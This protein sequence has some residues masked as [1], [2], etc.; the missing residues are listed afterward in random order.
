MATKVD[1]V[2]AGNK[3]IVCQN[4]DNIATLGILKRNPLNY[5][6]PLILMQF[7]LISLTSQMIEFC[8]RPL[9]QSS[10]VAQILGG[11]IYGPSALGHDALIGM[12]LFPAR[13]VLTLRTV[14][15]FGIMFFFFAVGV[16]S[17]SRMMVR[18][19][20]RAAVI[21]ISAMLST[22]VLT[23]SF[24]FLLI[25]YVHMDDSLSSAL[26][27]IAASQ[28]LTAFPNIACLLAELQLSSSDL[29]RIA[30]AAAMVCDIFGMGLVAV[31]LGIVQSGSDPV[32]SAL[33]VIS[34]CLFVIVMVYVIG[35]IIRIVIRSIPAGKP[36]AD[37]YVFF[38]FAGTLVTAFVTEVIGQHFILGPLVF[39]LLTPDGQP[40]GS[41]MVSKLDYPIGKFLYPTFLTTSGLKTNIF[42]IDRWSLLIVVLLI[43]FSCISKIAA[44]A[45]SSRFFDIRFKDSVVIGLMLNARGICELILYNLFRDNGV[46]TDKEFALCVISVVGVTAVITPLIRLLYDPSKQYLPSKRRTIQHMK[47]DAELRIVVCIKN[48]ENV[49]S[50]VDLLEASD[51]TEESPI[52][53]LALLLV[54][55]V[56]RTTPMLAA[57][58]S[59]QAL[60]STNSQSGHILG[61]LRQYQ[62]CHETCVTV[63]SFSVFSHLNST[64]DDICRVARDQKANIV[65][66]PFH[67]RWE[68]D[69]SIG[70]Q[71]RTVQNMNIKI[72]E[73]APCSVGIL[74]D[75][76]ILT[77]S[78]SILSNQ[79]IFQVAVI[80]IGGPDD[81]ESLFY[82]ARMGRRNNVSLTIL[83]FLLFGCDTARERKQDNNLIDEVRQANM[84]NQNNF[85][86]QERV[87]KDGVGLAASL[88]SLEDSFNLLLVGRHHH[89]SQ[90]LMG[91]GLGQRL[92]GEKLGHRLMRPMMISHEL[93]HEPTLP[94]AAATA[95]ATGSS[96]MNPRLE[97]SID[98]E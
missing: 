2:S 39:G 10:I 55:L 74:V 97:I 18:P 75:R 16:K 35:P 20:R 4:T 26:V 41:P 82:A 11:V 67:K 27:L 83:R 85:K 53:V 79:S 90:I 24:A 28:C 3:Y 36:L 94:P 66:L 60:Q 56:G 19:G 17:D 70:S 71:D 31:V 7:S 15:V 92:R 59:T 65:I 14:A 47:S 68:I 38:C 51:A 23:I 32:K 72:M 96:H 57:H 54:E 89:A 86:Y 5:S 98:R 6:V 22:L 1:A 63:Q 13:S 93:M 25:K 45:F 91:L 8:L 40:L 87:V 29:G 34:M 33:S 61:A 78:T 95:T 76:G 73:R 49:P 88:R 9:G 21:G 69:G 46:L 30:T 62:L 84:L 37:R 77:G 81:A 80:Y 58:Q 44:V 64:Q 50:I 48:Q 43:L 12:A 52:A 42:K